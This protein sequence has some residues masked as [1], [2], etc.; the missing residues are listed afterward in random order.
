MEQTLNISAYLAIAKRRIWYGLIPFLLVLAVAVVVINV[1][2]PIYR[3]SATVSI[4]SQQIPEHFVQ[5]TVVGYADQ[6]LA[7]I[8][9]RVMASQRLLDIIHKFNLFPKLHDKPESVLVAKFRDRISLDRILNPAAGGGGAV[10]F[11]LSFEYRDPNAAAE[12]VNTLVSLFLEENVRTRTER[13]AETT[14]FLK[15]ESERLGKQVAAMDALVAEYKQK[16]GNALPE[17]LDLHINMLQTAESSLGNVE[18]DITALEGDRRSLETQLATVGNILSAAGT[19]DALTLSPAQQLA[20]LKAELLRKS[21]IY[22]PAHPDV[23]NLRRRIALMEREV[24]MGSHDETGANSTA[25]NPARSQI[26]TQIQ[27]VE[28]QLAS[29]RKERTQLHAKIDSL[30][31]IIVETPQVERGLKDLSRDYESALAE[32]NGVSEK[33]RA[34]QLAENLETEQKAERFVLLEAAKVPSVPIWPDKRKSYAI[35]IVLSLGSGVGTAYLAEVLDSTIRGPAM[36]MSALQ[37][38]PLAVIP[39]IKCSADLR[40]QRFRWVWILSAAVIILVLAFVIILFY[41]YQPLD[42]F[43]RLLQGV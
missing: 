40:R 11:T 29:L 3:A 43:K 12:V 36:L 16:H 9:E 15:Q 31:A 41:Y 34:A 8:Q 10:A 27:S 32:Y 4:E 30:H 5:S 26:E 35:G 23:K 38:Y 42:I 22:S 14:G 7:Y 28:A 2:P 33:R 6:R 17:H 20:A 19:A 37:H 25:G 24:A 18:R 13:A 21:A 1:L 39:F